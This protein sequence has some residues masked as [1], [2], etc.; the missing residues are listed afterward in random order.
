MTKCV[1]LLAVLTCSAAA[2]SP[3]ERA[4]RL[5]A[6]GQRDEAVRILRQVVGANS[7]DVD[8]RLLLGSLLTEA[9][10]ESGAIQQ[11]TEAVRL[12]PRSAEAQNALG[13]AYNS[14]QHAQDA[15]A[16]FEKALA[17]DPNFGVAQLNLGSLLL[18]QGQQALAAEHLDRAIRLL[19]PG[20]DSAYAHY[21]RAKLFSARDDSSKAAAHLQQAVLERADF[22]EAWLDLGQARSTMQDGPGAIAAWTRA[23]ALAPANA[24]PEYRL[25]SEYLNSNQFEQAVQHLE[26]AHRLDPQSQQVLS[27][28]AIAFRKVG[29]QADADQIKQQL[30]ELLRKKSEA[31][32]TQV[33]AIQLNNQGAQLQK[34][35]DLRGALDKYRAALETYPDNSDVRVNYAVALLQL[36]QW[37][38]GL[39]QLHEALRREPGNAKIRA[40]LQDAL[41]QAPPGL[42]PKWTDEPKEKAGTVTKQLSQ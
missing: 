15:R 22:P 7:T 40:A 9:G 37:T 24:E 2:Q 33:A 1:L 27:A 25:G 5:A 19:K 12:R 41:A 8:A 3:V 10:D 29:R 17:A 30:V 35:G 4:W 42:A 31:A 28:L 16:C 21:L 13:E 18:S 14:F 38:E 32:R 6:N 11:L 23:A 39:N 20:E 34:K 36:G 26:T